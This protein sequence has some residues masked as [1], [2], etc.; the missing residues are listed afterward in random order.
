LAHTISVTNDRQ[1]SNNRGMTLVEILVVI[2]IMAVLVGLVTAGFS[3][4][5]AKSQQVTCLSNM[6]QIGVGLQSYADDHQGVYPETAHTAAQGRS[7]IY[8]LEEYLTDFQNVR[9]CPADP[10]AKE[11]LAMQGTSYILNSFVFVPP[12]D[13][14]G[15][16]DGPARNRLAS[17]P[18]PSGTILMF[19]CSDSVGVRAGDDHTHSD[20]WSSWG[21]VCRD[22]APDRH[23]RSGT[24]GLRGSSNYLFAD[25]HVEN[26]QAVDVKKRIDSGDNIANIPGVHD[27]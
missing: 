22:I 8:V 14:F 15:E 10:Q 1:K 18:Q 19:C 5:K 27:R 3:K 21:A 7:W 26:W 23:A 6:R 4:V 2:T 12:L 16:P 25:G 9:I 24:S 11:R 20:N 13:A 17:L